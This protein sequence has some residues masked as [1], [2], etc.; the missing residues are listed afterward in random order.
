MINDTRLPITYP[1]V[2]TVHYMI[3]DTRL[4]ITYPCI[5]T[6][7]Y[8]INATRSPITYPCIWTVHYMINDT[9]SPI[10]YPCV[11]TVHYMI[12][13]TRLPTCWSSK[14]KCITN[15]NIRGNV[16]WESLKR[17]RVNALHRQLGFTIGV[18]TVHLSTLAV[19]VSW[20]NLRFHFQ[21]L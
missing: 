18:I 2:W 16:V 4:P 8:M 13:D 6:V 5:W 12:N 11:W 20:R 3:N 9:R 15:Q 19:G 1:C 7:H 17:T 10:T 21:L 14:D